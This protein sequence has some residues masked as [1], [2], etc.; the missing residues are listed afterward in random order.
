M[1]K[2][3]ESPPLEGAGVASNIIALSQSE[4]EKKI[5]EYTPKKASQGKFHTHYVPS[6]L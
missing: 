5:A 1:D 3:V 2:V 6:L 4:V